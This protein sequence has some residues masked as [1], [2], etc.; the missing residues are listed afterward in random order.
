MIYLGIYVGHN[1]S[2]ALMRD[3]KIIYA[4]QEERFTNLKNFF[5]YPAKS[6]E[7]CLE[8][9]KS[10]NLIID[11]AAFS[12]ISHP[13][14]FSKYRFNNFFSISDF[15]KFYSVSLNK[16]KAVS[17]V[18]NHKKSKKNKGF[19]L[20]FD[21]LNQ[22]YYFNGKFGSSMLEAQLKKQAKQKIKKIIFLDHH[23]C[24]AYYSYFS[25]KN[26]KDNSCVVS[27]DSYGDGANQTV[28]IVKKNKL[29]LVA[30][31]N[32]F[33]IA[34][35][36]KFITLILNMKPEEHEFKVMGL[37]A[38]SKKRYILDAY[39]KIFKNI[40]KFNGI[41]IVHN[42]R[43]K[44]L[45]K[46]LKESTKNTR[47]DNIAGALQYFV[48][49]VMKDLLIRINKKYKVK[50]FYF[51]GGVSMNV[52]MYNSLGK[53]N[54]VNYLYS[55]PSGSDES[56][57][58]GACYYLSQNVK[59]HSLN[60]IYLGKS[61]VN[62][63]VKL[64]LELI[65]KKFSNNNY[66]VTINFNHKD[67]ASLLMKNEIIAVAR[68]REEFGARALGNRSIIANPSN[69]AVVQNINESIKNRDF[70][71]PFALTIL[72]E[73]HKKYVD[74][75]K[76][77]ECKYMTMSFDTKKNNF[78]KIK[79]GCHP[80]DKTVR[81]QILD[82]DSNPNYYS[83]IQ[84]FFKKTGIPA[85]LNTS[86]NLHGSPMASSLDDVIYTF[87]NSGLKYLYLNDN[88]LIKKNKNFQ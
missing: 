35:I 57:S 69:F 19:Y 82:K 41:K 2:A 3:G 61:L 51:S 44:N 72:K 88:F 47:F 21:K 8:Y 12:N 56:L 79:A 28:W 32:Q 27:V 74:N 46:F 83:I 24:H 5:G 30:R 53:L 60:N 45:Y 22:K 9:I 50:N 81:P 29:K 67:L 36:Y 23:T 54:F 43:P 18:K 16:K 48:E 75:K 66:K 84:N 52:K 63:D 68:G 37:S 15:H 34:R 73:Q 77:F 20:P 86:L 11:T 78:N 70:W 33:E 71:M 55:P 17:F 40:Q 64:N 59:T 1:A 13:L 58:I 62:K 42:K 65:K 26:R 7:Y 25:A 85:L 39:K 87:K 4:L 80:Y 49:K 10:K 14:F 6:I 31:T 76:N 38:Y